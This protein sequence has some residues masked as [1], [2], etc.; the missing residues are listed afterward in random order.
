V[1]VFLAKIAVELERALAGRCRT[2]GPGGLAA[3]SIAQTDA[4]SVEDLLCTSGPQDPSFEE[5]HS[6]VSIAIVLAGTF[7]YR[8]SAAHKGTGG[9]MTPGCLL[10]G[11][12]GQCFECG[13]EHASGDRC[14]SFHYSPDYFQRI[15]ADAGVK[16]SDRVFRVFRVPALREVSEIAL[17]A[18]NRLVG[19]TGRT[20][21]SPSWE[22]FGIQ[23]AVRAVHLANGA[24][25]EARAEPPSAVARVTRVLRMIENDLGAKL[26]L[27]RL[28]L[29]SRLSP[30][31]F[32]RTFQQ[33]TGLTPHQYVRRTRLREAAVRLSTQQTK[34][35]DI[36][37]DCG[38][39]DV[40]NFNRAFRNEF[41]GNPRQLNQKGH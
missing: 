10:L 12:R 1:E 11:N 4:W 37:L 18:C 8:A 30:Y 20:H 16:R 33:L 19:N 3:R 24:I 26:T 5:Q 21:G 14:L 32:L 28:A 17:R 31:H 7:Q 13:H 35:L 29:E 38:F 39:G 41:G 9:L 34:V 27:D 40:S 2:G 36:A 6:R 25:T 23:L 15:L 22:E